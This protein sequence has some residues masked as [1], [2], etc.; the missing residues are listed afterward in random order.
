MSELQLTYDVRV[1]SVDANKGKRRT[2]YRV[3][4]V[5][6]RVARTRTFQT[7]KLADSFRAE[8]QSAATKGKA[9]DNASGLPAEMARQA[10][11]VTWYAHAMEFVATKWPRASAKSRRSIAESLATVTPALTQDGRGRPTPDEIRALLYHWTFNLAARSKGL[12]REY[13]NTHEWMER[14]SR[15]L[16]DLHNASL[17]R[18]ALDL[19]ALKLDGTQAAQTTI[20]RK[21]A[22]FYGA[23]RY[24]VER[25]RL[26]T[27]PMEK[28]QWTTPKSDDEV[29]RRVVVNPSQAASILNAVRRIDPAMEAFYGCMYYAALRPG[30]AL[31]LRESD[32]TLPWTGWGE[33]LLTGSTQ[34][35]G[36]WGDKGQAQEDLSLKHRSRTATRTVPASP[37][38]VALLRQHIDDFGAGPEGRLFV[39]RT[40]KARVPVAGPFARPVSPASYGNTWRRARLMALTPEQATSPM[41]RRP[42]DLRHACVSLWLN[43]GVPATTVAEWAGHSVAVLLRVYAKCVDGEGEA[44]KRRVEAA[45]NLTTGQSPPPT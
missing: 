31:H 27:H 2:T 4:W 7:R 45:L 18:S 24:A 17:T 36:A 22:V 9:F 19:L 12:P 15:P 30:E 21:R 10:S 34:Y 14:N 39:S 20:A 42:Y 35:V 1:W 40:G 11:E 26:A 8:L 23:L 43:A 37:E 38:L 32:C 28:V 16:T 6:A 44:A 29:D 25:D 5:V 3:R 13:A 41:A 33:L